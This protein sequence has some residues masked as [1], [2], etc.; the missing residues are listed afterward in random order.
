ME[1]IS[2]IPTSFELI[3][4]FNRM[5]NISGLLFRTSDKYGDLLIKKV[6]GKE[7]EQYIFTTPKFYY[8]GDT[9]SIHHFKPGKFPKFE[10]I[11]IY[12]KLDGTNICM[13]RYQDE[14]GKIFTS[15]KT[16]LTPFIESNMSTPFKF[17]WEKMM[18]KYKEK[19]DNLELKVEFNFGFELFGSFNKIL[20]KYEEVLDVKLLY[21]L[22]RESGDLL[23][24]EQFDF[25]KP[26]LLKEITPNQDP[27]EI[28]KE[29]LSKIEENFQG[30]RS[31]EGVMFY[32]L[33]EQN[34]IAYKC[35]PYCVIGVTSDGP[36]IVGYENAYNTALNAAESI[37]DISQLKEETYQLLQEEYN[38]ETIILSEIYISKAIQDAYNEIM[39]KKKVIECYQASNIEWTGKNKGEIMKYLMSHFE[40]KKSSQVFAIISDYLS[41]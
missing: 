32:I 37:S 10:K 35:K 7:C 8:P 2:E 41:M 17:M 28:Y 3:D 14:E 22:K 15:F 6:N 23:D 18:Q 12:D 21:A 4:P 40:K 30:N 11:K 33:Q 39:M 9:T 36:E 31:Q 24:P 16:R 25:P 19:F 26:S 38:Q 5:N 20:V 34:T 1:K 27:D 13:F 29:F